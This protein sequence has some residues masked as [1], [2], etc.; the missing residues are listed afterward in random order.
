MRTHA[1]GCWLP[2]DDPDKL[3]P[4]DDTHYSGYPYEVDA[5]SAE[6][7]AVAYLGEVFSHRDFDKL[8]RC[9]VAVEDGHGVVTYHLVNVWVNV[10]VVHGGHLPDV[11]PDP[12]QMCLNLDDVRKV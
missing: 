8:E 1:F 10:S 11:P 5:V 12:R 6:E 3:G 2:K 9:R 4:D 7:A